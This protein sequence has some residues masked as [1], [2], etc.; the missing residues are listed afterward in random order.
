MCGP[1]PALLWW[2]AR[3]EL[4]RRHLQAG[5]R[6]GAHGWP[7][8]RGHGRGQGGM[9]RRGHRGGR[10]RRAQAASPRRCNAHPGRHGHACRGV[11]S[12]SRWRPRGTPGRRGAHRG[13]CPERRDCSSRGHTPRHLRVLPELRASGVAPVGRGVPNGTQGSTHRLDLVHSLHGHVC[14]QPVLR[15]PG[16][17]SRAPRSFHRVRVRQRPWALVLGMAHAGDSRPDSRSDSRP[18]PGAH[19]NVLLCAL[20]QRQCLHRREGDAFILHSGPCETKRP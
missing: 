11:C 6:G 15:A 12:H 8:P 7:L 5:R 1:L 19:H 16:V 17:L 14:Q 9:H 3:A 4:R 18:H 10:P 2:R 20:R 13:G